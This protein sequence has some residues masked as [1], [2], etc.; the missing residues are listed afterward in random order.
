MNRWP[1]TLQTWVYIS[2]TIYA[3][4]WGFHGLSIHLHSNA[5]MGY[6]WLII[7]H[8]IMPTL[9][10]PLCIV[11]VK[12]THRQNDLNR[13]ISPPGPL[14][15]AGEKIAYQSWRA[16]DKRLFSLCRP[17]SASLWRT[18]AAPFQPCNNR[19]AG[20]SAPNID[21]SSGVL[22][23]Q[24]VGERSVI[25]VIYHLFDFVA[26]SARQGSRARATD[27]WERGS[28][29]RAWLTPAGCGVQVRGGGHSPYSSLSC[30]CGESVH[31]AVGILAL[32]YFF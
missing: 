14:V 7:R 18:S 6:S 2:P 28:V 5:L 25:N 32:C 27:Q 29:C 21:S 10:S 12:M 1:C 30:F 19:A 24:E 15:Y 11:K 17:A 9:A 31:S 3:H 26:A 4:I 22:M 13:F 20:C 8:F 23:T 16:G